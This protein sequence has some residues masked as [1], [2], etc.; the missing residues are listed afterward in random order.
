MDSTDLLL[1]QL[2]NEEVSIYSQN[3]FGLG[4]GF[5]GH[6][7]LDEAEPQM[8]EEEAYPSEEEQDSVDEELDGMEQEEAD[9]IEEETEGMEVAEVGGE[10]EAGTV[11][12]D[13]YDVDSQSA[14]LQTADE[15]KKNAKSLLLVSI[16]NSN[17][18]Y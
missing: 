14:S 18:G 11:Q 9:D 1:Q 6:Q 17:S 3:L 8:E 4:V 7:N 16:Y 15:V 5:G 10:V 2:L 13:G 12:G